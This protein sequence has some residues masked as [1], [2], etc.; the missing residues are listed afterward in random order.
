MFRKRFRPKPGFSKGPLPTRYVILITFIFFSSTSLVSLWIV[1]K[2]IEPVIMDIAK[3]E[4]K[5]VASEVI[6]D[7]VDKNILKQ[8]DKEEVVLYDKNGS[9]TIRFNPKYYS[10]IRADTIKDI[11]KKL[12]LNEENPF[13]KSQN[14]KDQFKSIVYYIPLGVVTGN[15]ILANLGPKVPV[16]MSLVGDVD[17][18]ERLKVTDTGINSSYIELFINFTV[19]VKVVIP[20]LTAETQVKHEVKIGDYLFPGKVPNYYG[21]MPAPAIIQPG[22]EEKK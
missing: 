8:L 6:N 2:S 19:N 7:S 12:G 17:S 9:G 14:T 16:K 20:S 11:Q 22:T 4:I 1:N 15:A 3:N 13:T 21:N 18:T 5:R 10:S